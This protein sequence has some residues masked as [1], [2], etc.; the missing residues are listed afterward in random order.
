MSRISCAIVLAVLSWG[1]AFAGELVFVNGTRLA[2]ELSNESLIVSTGAGLI[3]FG[4]PDIAF[5]SRDEVRLRDGRVI[6]GTLVG[7]QI[8]A[9]T[10]L[11]EIAIRID[12]LESYRGAAQAAPATPAAPAGSPVTG[13]APASGVTSS[14]SPAPAVP[15][16]G[17]G[18]PTIASYQDGGA[19]AR[20]ASTTGGTVSGVKPAV[21]TNGA[22]SAG[23]TRLEVVGEGALYRDALFGSS[24]I[25]TV[26]RGQQVIYVDSIDRRL[27]ILNRLVFD[28]GHWV[29][30]RLT[31]GT[32]GW[33]PAE[34]VR[35]LR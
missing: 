14:P 2:G 32:E 5:L 24:Q 1:T 7:G 34:S 27:R 13:V 21:L 29:K 6:R 16:V 3:E 12:E 22:T 28:G 26:P 31:D 25:G 19:S 10:A 9:Q 17:S 20:P 18:L 15:V 8:K 4:S 11:G 23:P 33:I 30:V 35:E